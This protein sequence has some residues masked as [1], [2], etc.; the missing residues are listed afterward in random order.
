MTGYI[1]AILNRFHHPHPNKPELAPHRYASRSFSVANA[2]APIPD[3]DTAHLDTSGVL[4]VQRIVGCILY[5]TR[6]IDSPL[7]PALTEISSDQAKATEETLAVTKNSLILSPHSPTLSFGTSPVTCVSGLTPTPLLHPSAT[8][9]SRVGGLF[10]LSSHP[11][12]TPKNI[13]P[14]LNGPI[15]VLCRIMKMVLLYAAEAE[16]GGIFIDTKEGVSIR[17][18][19]QELVHENP[20]TGTPLKTDNSTV[21]SIVNNNIS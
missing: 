3:N 10:Y 7:L 13:N 12:K 16:Y 1:E 14:P 9:R 15:Y 19:L 5:Y 17:T 11:F 4:C 6:A 8:P 20:K 21:H 2:Q 18:T